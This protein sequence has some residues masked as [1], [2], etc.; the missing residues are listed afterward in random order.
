MNICIFAFVLMIPPHVPMCVMCVCRHVQRS[1]WTEIELWLFHTRLP[2]LSS[3]SSPSVTFLPLYN[4]KPNSPNS[5]NSNPN[6]NPNS[7]NKP[8]NP[9]RPPLVLYDKI[10]KFLRYYDNSGDSE[11]KDELILPYAIYALSREHSDNN[12]KNF[13]KQLLRFL[14]NIF[15]DCEKQ[16]LKSKIPA[17]LP[18][19]FPD[20]FMSE[21]ENGQRIESNY[22][23][24]R[25][26]VYTFIYIYILIIDNNL[27]VYGHNRT[28][29]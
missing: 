29:L 19:P 9:S 27:V 14:K 20:P 10:S 15:Q 13:K 1:Q 5:P 12:N 4:P 17:I 18:P 6:S 24:D 16:Y 28:I 3:L 2:N 23:I 11:T 22:F 8:Y 26:Y 21:I 25:M 7:P